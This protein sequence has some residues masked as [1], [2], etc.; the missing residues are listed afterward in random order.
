MDG[1]CATIVDDETIY[2]DSLTYVATV[3]DSDSKK[4]WLEWKYVYLI[5]LEIW[6]IHSLKNCPALYHFEKIL[7]SQNN[8]PVVVIEKTILLNF[9]Q[10][11][12]MER[13][14]GFQV[15]FIFFC[16]FL[17]NKIIEINWLGSFWH[18]SRGP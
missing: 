8:L 11:T 18:K 13:P 3:Y 5:Y 6:V 7:S 12:D 15:S 1:N 14:T 4:D 10:R 9:Q 2:D 16:S 17:Y